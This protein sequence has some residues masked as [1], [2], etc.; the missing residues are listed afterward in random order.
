MTIEGREEGGIL[1]MVK[2]LTRK[3]THLLP[4]KTWCRLGVF[5]MPLSPA[6]ISDLSMYKMLQLAAAAAENEWMDSVGIQC[7]GTLCARVYAKSRKSCNGGY[8]GGGPSAGGR[9]SE[10]L[11]IEGIMQITRFK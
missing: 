2:R 5:A 6:A 3:S 8:S 1:D 4:P 11:A 10:A 7:G 9:R